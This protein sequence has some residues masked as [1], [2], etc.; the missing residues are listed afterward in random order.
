M[1]DGTIPHEELEF[2]SKL[3]VLIQE[4]TAMSAQERL[5]DNE[6]ARKCADAAMA[7]RKYHESL[8]V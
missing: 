5:K 1:N 6:A 3:V 8:H 7:L 4:L 2:A